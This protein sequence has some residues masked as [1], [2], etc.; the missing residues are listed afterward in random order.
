MTGLESTQAKATWAMGS[1]RAS[2]T[3]YT[4]CAIFKSSSLYKRLPM[5]SVWARS[6]SLRSLFGLRVNSPLA[7]GEYGITPIF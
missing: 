6:V 5:A 1:P 2:A 7:T 3:S 4:R